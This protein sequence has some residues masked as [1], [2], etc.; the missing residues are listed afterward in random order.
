MH[1]NAQ[2]SP[3]PSLSQIHSLSHSLFQSLVCVCKKKVQKHADMKIQEQ[4]TNQLANTNTHTHTLSLSLTDTHTKTHKHYHTHIHTHTHTHTNKHT[5]T[6]THT[7]KFTQIEC[8]FLFSSFHSPGWVAFSQIFFVLWFPQQKKI[9]PWNWHARHSPQSS[10]SWTEKAWWLSTSSV[11]RYNSC[12]SKGL[13]K[14]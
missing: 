1:F 5:H 14:N 12:R 6:H 9:L 4:K 3:F 11:C 2:A 13:R 8:W 10:G 7:Q